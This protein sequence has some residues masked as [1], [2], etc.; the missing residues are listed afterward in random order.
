[1]EKYTEFEE[2][3]AQ[4]ALLNKKLEKEVIVNERLIRRAMKEKATGIR[5]KIIVWGI[6]TILMVPYFIWVMPAVVG[7]SMEFCCFVAFFLLLASGYSGYIYMNFR[8][9]EFVQGDLISARKDTLKLKKLYAFWLKFI[10]IP[11]IIVFLSWFFYEVTRLYQ[12]EYLEGI[13]TGMVVGALI[14]GVIG[15]FQYRKIQR[16]ANDIIEQINEVNLER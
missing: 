3:K 15:S 6:A 7:L 8:P 5:R 16:A 4:L 12:G 11:F 13:L 10:G 14:G 9:Q 1:M 2:M